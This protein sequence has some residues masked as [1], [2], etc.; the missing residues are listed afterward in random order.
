M[1]VAEDNIRKNKKF[2]TVDLVKIGRD[3]Y[4]PAHYPIIVERYFNRLCAE[5]IVIQLGTHSGEDLYSK[6][7]LAEYD[8]ED[9]LISLK[10]MP[11]IEDYRKEYFRVIINNSAL[12][13]F[14]LRKYKNTVERLIAQFESL[15]TGGKGIQI[16]YKKESVTLK[17]MEMRFRFIIDRI[18]SVTDRVIV[19]YLPRP[20]EYMKNERRKR[21]MTLAALKTVCSDSGV[22]IVD[23]SEEFYQTFKIQHQAVHG[24]INTIPGKGHLNTVGH[25]LV[26]KKVGECV[27]EMLNLKIEKSR[28]Y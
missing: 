19:L 18:L 5:G 9:N 3:G 13:Y 17:D 28:I 26:G 4:I 1:Q 6:E 23:M 20:G 24:F 14:L 25:K 27:L 15:S 2:N 16:A 22:K 7:V 12:I 21:D 11:R 8:K 10:I